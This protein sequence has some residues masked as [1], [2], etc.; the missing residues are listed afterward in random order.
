MYLYIEIIC[1]GNGEKVS[2]SAFKRQ[3]A[4]RVC[5]TDSSMLV[6]LPIALL[7]NKCTTTLIG[8][9]WRPVVKA[10]SHVVLPLLLGPDTDC[11]PINRDKRRVPTGGVSRAPQPSV[12]TLLHSM[13]FCF[14]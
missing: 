10:R 12:F 9:N 4:Y 3:A 11:H 5:I 7:H 1:F 6:K 8:H 14:L 2:I 13:Q